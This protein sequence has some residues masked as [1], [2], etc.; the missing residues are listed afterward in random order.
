MHIHISDKK[1]YCTWNWC[2][3]IHALINRSSSTTAVYHIILLY[4]SICMI[5]AAVVVR[6]SR[7]HYL[8]FGVHR[9]C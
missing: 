5:S 6:D 8:S 3:M 7:E 4:T 2:C 9:C 1:L